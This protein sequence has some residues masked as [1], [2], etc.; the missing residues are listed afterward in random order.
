[1]ELPN[2]AMYACRAMAALAAFPPGTTFKAGDLAELANIPRSYLSKVARRLVVAE[3]LVSQK[4]HGGGFG[5]A[6][7]PDQIKFSEILA[8]VGFEASIDVCGFGLGQCDAKDPC[9]LHQSW[10]PLK[11]HF[12]KWATTTTLAEVPLR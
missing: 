2:T 8:A 9:D 10:A 4:G 12:V 7:P 11:K 5:L 3:L 1:M 6:R